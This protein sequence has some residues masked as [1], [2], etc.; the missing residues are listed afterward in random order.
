MART[1]LPKTINLVSQR[2][3][4][5]AF[6]DIFPNG[7][8][9][10]LAEFRG[11]VALGYKEDFHRKV[12]DTL[13]MTHGNILYGAEAGDKRT[14]CGLPAKILFSTDKRALESLEETDRFLEDY[15]EH[16]HHGTARYMRYAPQTPYRKQQTIIEIKPE[17]GLFKDPPLSQETVYA[18]LYLPEKAV[19]KKMV[20][21]DGARLSAGSAPKPSLSGY[22]L[23]YEASRSMMNERNW[24]PLF[25][26]L[27]L[28]AVDASE[29]SNGA[30]NQGKLTLIS[31]EHDGNNVLEWNARIHH[32]E[33]KYI[34][35]CA[36]RD[37]GL[38]YGI[39]RKDGKEEHSIPLY[40]R[41]VRFFFSDDPAAL[42]NLPRTTS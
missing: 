32:R 30:A 17:S 1:E 5:K 39:K 36:Y 6:A 31:R 26:A 14:I 4:G 18:C 11:A 2:Y 27:G 24:R 22:H 28:D 35:G 20:L 12:T 3:L 42:D 16:I 40:F 33:E 34:D 7:D 21:P 29:Y 15:E 13:S 23:Q 8:S 10:H 38:F 41:P 19:A 37:A 9:T 25:E